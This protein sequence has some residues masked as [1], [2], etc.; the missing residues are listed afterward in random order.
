MSGN[1]QTTPE[2]PSER[3]KGSFGFSAYNKDD[4]EY[5]D[6]ALVKMLIYKEA[7]GEPI[8]EK[9]VIT[10]FAGPLV[11]RV[12]ELEDLNKELAQIIWQLKGR[13]EKA[14]DDLEDCNSQNRY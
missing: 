5:Y 13:L 11:D 10:Q 3:F 9:W 14:E 12:K 7:I 4:Q 2:K 1:K 8:P 6:D